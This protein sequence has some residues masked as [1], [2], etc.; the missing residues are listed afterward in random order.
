[1]K[2][3][4][5]LSLLLLLSLLLGLA[6]PALAQLPPID[7]YRFNVTVTFSPESVVAG[8]EFT[9]TVT[10]DTLLA[11][12]L[13]Y[14]CEW[15]DPNG[16]FY[17]E[18]GEAFVGEAVIEERLPYSGEWMLKTTVTLEN[19][20]VPHPY[21][22]E[23]TMEV[24]PVQSLRAGVDVDPKFTV[25][26]EDVTATVDV[27]GGVPPYTYEY[28]WAFVEDMAP[29]ASAPSTKENQNKQKLPTG[30]TKGKTCLVEVKVTD[31]SDPA[32][33]VTASKTLSVYYYGLSLILK[34]SYRAGETLQVTIAPLG[35][36][37]P[38]QY[39]A[40][41]L[42]GDGKAWYRHHL[43]NHTGEIITLSHKLTYGQKGYLE[44]TSIDANGEKSR[45]YAV[46]TITE[47]PPAADW[48]QMTDY[49]ADNDKPREG[50]TL[51]ITAQAKGGTLPYRIRVTYYD[52]SSDKLLGTAEAAGLEASFTVPMPNAAALGIE[53]AV[54]DKVGRIAV[55]PFSVTL[56]VTPHP[57]LAG[58]ANGDGSVDLKDMMQ[59][60]NYIKTGTFCTFMRNA[61]A[62]EKDGVDIKDLA[63]I[64]NLL[65]K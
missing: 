44:V 39:E 58:D 1:M 54:F 43:G 11:G 28:T 25:Q 40:G 48:L 17:G 14:H 38:Y 33:S 3:T 5:S 35:G 31:S 52:L 24:L 4:R 49:K 15:Y 23:K 12:K 13:S 37:P 7:P 50:E 6:T 21:K 47:S 19:L 22:E 18:F 8:Q 53:A 2:A 16:D 56:T 27:K 62:D 57:R 60:V 9:V 32:K 29:F 34:D 36:T 46:F 63:Y 65:I 55:L 41:L 51:T 30:L 20:L 64:V 26:G 59:I 10:V 45:N 61:D 42:I